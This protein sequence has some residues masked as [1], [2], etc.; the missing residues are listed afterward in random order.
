MSIVFYTWFCLCNNH[1]MFQFIKYIDVILECCKT[2]YIYKPILYSLFSRYMYAPGILVAI[3]F[4]ESRRY[5]WKFWWVP[6]CKNRFAS[7]NWKWLFQD[8]S[9]WVGRVSVQ[10]QCVQVEWRVYSQT[11]DV[12]AMTVCPSGVTCLLTD[13]WCKSNDSVSK[14]SDMSTHRLLM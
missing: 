3:Y 6:H 13:C 11:V 10:W 5:F 7:P 14:W 4:D 1:C 9:R 8:S 12:R 2:I